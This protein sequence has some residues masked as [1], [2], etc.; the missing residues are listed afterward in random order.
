[1]S[2]TLASHLLSDMLA[3]WLPRQRWFPGRGR[4]ASELEIISDTTLLDGDPQ[5]RHLIVEAGLAAP[6]L[7]PAG[8][9]PP[10]AAGP[11]VGR[12]RFQLLLGC[13]SQLP[14]GIRT[15]AV[16]GQL[17]GLACY[18]ALHDPE[19]ASVLMAGIA[20]QRSAGPLRF[21]REPA[22]SLP[23]WETVRLLTAEQSNT[24]LVFG[25]VAILKVLRRLFPGANPDLEVADALARLGSD[26]VAAPFGWIETQLDGEP[27]LLAVL[28][29]FLAGASD[30][31]S[32]ATTALGRLYAR[33]AA[34]G[35]DYLTG[36]L[37][38]DAAPAGPVPGRTA[39]GGPGSTVPGSTGP[40]STGPGEAALPFAAPAR[41]LGL[42]TAQMHV[43][44][45]TAFGCRD[46][47]PAER[48]ALTGTLHAKLAAAV[49]IVPELKA[50]A[51]RIAAAYD[52]LARMGGPVVLQRIHGDYHLGQVM[53]GEH[54]WVA[55]DF[56]GE[57]AAPLAERRALAPALRD[58]A[59]MLRSF[60]YAA[61]HQLVGH[62]ERQELAATASAWV[63]QSQREFCAGYSAGGGA[64]PSDQA[65]LLRALTLEK[66]VY[67]VV[68]EHRHR[69]AWLSIPLDF[70][71]A[72]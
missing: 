21:V 6:E 48:A 69:P 20:G 29:E 17:P 58:V 33:Q 26:R 63:A 66:A 36:P 16:L 35:Q 4:P 31:W 5:L 22:A 27:V 11:G 65:P 39:P 2:D 8:T 30:G 61:R 43:D 14:A 71:A 59:G 42:A 47:S 40:S 56:E 41:Q 50:H 28:S 68:Y 67:E 70:V 34:Y 55:L 13:R 32:L 53:Y 3:A 18:D 38:P 44:M 1:M 45:A 46:M 7:A 15:E 54:G 52:E 60:D 19:L 24:S 62:P 37:A 9:V 64:D 72:A 23:D 25:E 10:R 49:A 51:A 57:P 12:A